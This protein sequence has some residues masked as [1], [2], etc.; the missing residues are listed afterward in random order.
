CQLRK[1]IPAD[2][3][4][5]SGLLQPIQERRRPQLLRLSSERHRRK[6]RSAR[7]LADGHSCC[8][9]RRR[10]PLPILPLRLSRAFRG[11]P[12]FLPTRSR[13][14]YRIS[15]SKRR[16]LAL[17]KMPPRI[18][19]GL[20]RLETAPAREWRQANEGAE[21]V[22]PDYESTKTLRASCP[23]IAQCRCRPLAE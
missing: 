14:D 13:A 20:R 10:P 16:F 15:K 5:R 3:Q 22:L 2:R 19:D 9:K 7:K 21:T 18:P 11:L 8:S 23:S 4:S 17:A 6:S 1:C 12:R